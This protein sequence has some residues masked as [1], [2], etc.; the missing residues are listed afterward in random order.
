MKNTLALLAVLG[1]FA[2]FAQTPS[3]PAVA[4]ASLEVA[5]EI[6]C[7]E[8]F[9]GEDPEIRLTVT[10]ISA[11]TLTIDKPFDPASGYLA[12]LYRNGQISDIDIWR[13]WNTDLKP[14]PTGPTA[15]SLLPGESRTM[16]LRLSE[17]CGPG[18]L[19]AVCALPDAS[20]QRDRFRLAYHYGR[21]GTLRRETGGEFSIVFPKL[22]QWAEADLG[23]DFSQV[24]VLPSPAGPD[25]VKKVTRGQYLRAAVLSHRGKR[26]L[27]SGPAILAN[28]R[29]SPPAYPV[30]FHT[31]HARQFKPYH[32]IAEVKEGTDGSKV[33]IDVALNGDATVSYVESGRA[34]SVRI[35]ADKIRARK[36]EGK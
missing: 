11:E 9:P 16:Q 5:I 18:G 27:V 35:T 26:Y 32:R 22:E 24:Q 23:G 20:G 30:V 8:C 15:V 31:D 4:Q 28:P 10:N 7:Q 25:V 29:W 19:S 1:H 2:T 3:A 6:G 14:R 13:E 34:K 33:R 21:A 17:T 12:I 36:P